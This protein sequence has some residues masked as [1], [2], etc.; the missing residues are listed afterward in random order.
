MTDI[1]KAWAASQVEGM[2]DGTLPPADAQRMR[3]AMQRDPELQAAVERAAALRRELRA[4]NR[5]AV[6]H[7]FLRRLLAVP[8]VHGRERRA[9]PRRLAWLAT[10]AATLAV[11]GGTLAVLEQREARERE[12]VAAR[13]REAAEALAQVRLAMT[14]LQRTSEIAGAHVKDAV[15]TSLIA[16]LETSREAMEHKEPPSADGDGA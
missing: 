3:A 11:A 5:V 6:P 1:E 12:A 8:A 10:A 15:L 4:L 14:Y 13:E 7:G 9:R 2:A 16:A